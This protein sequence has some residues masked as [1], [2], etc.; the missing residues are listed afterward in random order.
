M[1]GVRVVS[2]PFVREDTLEAFSLAS[3]QV[4]AERIDCANFAFIQSRIQIL[5][6]WVDTEL[7][8]I[9]HKLFEGIHAS[10]LLPKAAKTET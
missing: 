3:L 10:M 1:K 5:S 8:T 2:P 4:I 9:E 7:V 6:T